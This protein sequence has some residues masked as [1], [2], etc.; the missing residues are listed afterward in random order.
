MFSL[1]FPLSLDQT[2]HGPYCLTAEMTS[3]LRS[4]APV[5]HYTG[6]YLPQPGQVLLLFSGSSFW[7]QPIWHFYSNGSSFGLLQTRLDILDPRPSALVYSTPAM[8]SSGAISAL[9]IVEAFY[10]FGEA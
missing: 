9:R 4:K 8:A 10:L 7:N 3:R 2:T 1:P 5:F 6:Q